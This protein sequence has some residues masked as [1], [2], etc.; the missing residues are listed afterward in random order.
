MEKYL[1]NVS[2]LPKKGEKIEHN[3]KMLVVAKVDVL[4]ESGDTNVYV[5]KESWFEKVLDTWHFWIGFL[6][7]IAVINGFLN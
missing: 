3:G 7:L 5:R 2:T 4:N 1:K 6:W